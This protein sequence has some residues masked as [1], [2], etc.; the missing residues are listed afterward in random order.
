MKLNKVYFTC[1]GCRKQ[2]LVE[3]ESE[4][5]KF[6]YKDGWLFL[7]NMDIKASENLTIPIKDKHFCCKKCLLKF[8]CEKLGEKIQ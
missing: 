7:Y 6:P 8:I 2:K 3:G 4:R 5:Q 1:D